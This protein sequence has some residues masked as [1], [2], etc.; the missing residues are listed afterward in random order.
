MPTILQRIYCRIPLFMPVRSTKLLIFDHFSACWQLRLPNCWYHDR[1]IKAEN[2]SGSTTTSGI[3]SRGKCLPY[4]HE[5][6]FI[7]VSMCV[8]VIYISYLT[9]PSKSPPIPIDSA[10]ITFL[11]WS[12]WSVKP[13]WNNK[14]TEIKEMQTTEILQDLKKR[15]WMPHQPLERY[16]LH[17]CRKWICCGDSPWS[18]LAFFSETQHTSVTAKSNE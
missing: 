17:S 5:L 13:R 8:Y 10:P 2:W 1:L 6:S 14:S 3:C 15:T 16:W 9:A 12:K 18:T 7:L 4:W 11:M